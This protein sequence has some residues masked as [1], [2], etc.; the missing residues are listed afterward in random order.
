MKA[1]DDD[2]FF[3]A[4][5]MIADM[6]ADE[7]FSYFRTR[8][9]LESIPG[10]IQSP[11][12]QRYRSQIDGLLTVPMIATSRGKI[13]RLLLIGKFDGDFDEGDLSLSMQLAQSVAVAVENARLTEALTTSAR[14][15]DE[16]LAMLGH[17]LRNPFGRYS[18]RHRQRLCFTLRSATTSKL[19]FD[20]CCVASP[21]S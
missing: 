8:D 1:R 5:F 10:V 12:W 7:D 11:E 4:A 14:R 21:R 3:K 18:D 20:R 16:F 15:K 17:E 9:E 13:G 19:K 2:T 6:V